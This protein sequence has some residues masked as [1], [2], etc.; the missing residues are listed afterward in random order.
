MKHDNKLMAHSIIPVMVTT[1]TPH[2]NG[3][4][5]LGAGALNANQ[6]LLAICS[7]SIA[8]VY[9]AKSLLLCFLFHDFGGNVAQEV[10]HEITKYMN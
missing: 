6:S 3:C 4:V 5:F 2:Y 10:Q 1:T 7:V 9:R 8:F